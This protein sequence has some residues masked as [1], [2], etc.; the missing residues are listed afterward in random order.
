M[1]SDAMNRKT[2]W[3]QLEKIAIEGLSGWKSK[4]HRSHLKLKMS[5]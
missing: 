4:M 3:S 1:G 2:R 5:L